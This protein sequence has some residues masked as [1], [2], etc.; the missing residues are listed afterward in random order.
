MNPGPVSPLQFFRT[1]LISLKTLAALAF[2]LLFAYGIYS[3][4]G[5][6]TRYSPRDLFPYRFVNDIDIVNEPNQLIYCITSLFGILIS[7]LATNE[8]DI[9]FSDCRLT[10]S[11]MCLKSPGTHVG[12]AGFERCPRTFETHFTSD[13]FSE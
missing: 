11:K 6:G 1:P 8:L 13:S 10:P 9:F 3:S 7:K 12:A 2:V 5:R 4:G